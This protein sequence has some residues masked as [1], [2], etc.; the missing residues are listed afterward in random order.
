MPNHLVLFT[1]YSIDT[2]LKMMEVGDKNN[3]QT[4]ECS[5]LN[6]QKTA[7]AS[8]FNEAF[9]YNC[10]TDDGPMLVLKRTETIKTARALASDRGPGT[11]LMVTQVVAG[12]VLLASFAHRFYGREKRRFGLDDVCIV[13]ALTPERFR[14]VTGMCMF[15]SPRPIVLAVVEQT[16]AIMIANFMSKSFLC[17]DNHDATTAKPVETPA[18]AAQASMAD[19]KAVILGV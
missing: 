15:D 19:K 11:T 4:F 10:T 17:G 7:L 16:V 3:Y 5:L 18:G 12:C 8:V 6:L 13:I 14:T 2:A 1:A 9:D